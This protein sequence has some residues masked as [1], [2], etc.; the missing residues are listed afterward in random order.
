MVPIVADYTA[1][2]KRKRRARDNIQR[3]FWNIILKSVRFSATWMS[4]VQTV[5]QY[6]DGPR[7]S[8]IRGPCLLRLYDSQ[9]VLPLYLGS[10]SRPCCCVDGDSKCLSLAAMATAS[11]E[12]FSSSSCSVWMYCFISFSLGP[13]GISNLAACSAHFLDKVF[14]SCRT[15]WTHWFVSFT[16]VVRLWINSFCSSILTFSSVVDGCWS[17]LSLDNYNK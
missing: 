15:R 13:D 1:W 11:L 5:G 8:E 9:K 17:S 6:I 14:S 4:V 16:C 10:V 3:K 12:R 7:V 2:R